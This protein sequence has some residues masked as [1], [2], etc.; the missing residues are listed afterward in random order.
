MKRFIALSVALIMAV[1]SAGCSRKQTWIIADL[2]GS[3]STKTAV[4]LE[5]DFYTAVNKDWLSTAKIPDGY[6]ETSSFADR[7]IEVRQQ[8]MALLND[9]TQTGHEAQLIRTLYAQYTD[10]ETRNALGV[11]PLKPYLDRIMA[12]EDIDDLTEYILYLAENTSMDGMLTY[13]LSAPDYYDSSKKCIWLYSPNFSLG[14]ADEYRNMSY[15]GEI[16]KEA[17]ETMLIKLLMHAGMTEDEAQKINDDFFELETQI[18]RASNGTAA[19]MQEDYADKI[20]NPVTIAELEARSPRYPIVGILQPYIDAGIKDFILAEPAW[21]VHMNELY[22]QE[23]IELF[24][25]YMIRSLIVPMAEIMDEACLEILNE[26]SVAVNGVPYEQDIKAAGLNYCLQQMEWMIG[27]M[28]ADAYANEETQADVTALVEDIL[29]VYK[30]QLENNDRL[31]ESARQMAV[32]KLDNIRVRVGCPQDWTLYDASSLVFKSNEDGGNLVDNFFA[33]TKYYVD[34]YVNMTAAPKDVNRWT[35][36]PHTVTVLYSNTDNSI[37]VTAGAL[38]GA[39]YDPAASDEQNMGRIGTLIA[40]E[41]SHAFDDY[42]SLFDKDGNHY[43][44]WTAE[45]VTAYSERIAEIAAYWGSFD[46][47]KRMPVNGPLVQSEAAA[48]LVGM[49]CMLELANTMEGF[50]YREFFESYAVMW[51]T[52]MTAEEL[53]WRAQNDANP[54]RYLR[55]NATVQQ[56]EEFYDAY[57]IAEGDGMYLAP[58]AR[59]SIW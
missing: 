2:Q 5:D 59:L 41:I 28:Y 54:P 36:A 19:S 42:G 53:E 30:K 7:D 55:I 21:L 13:L 26:Y 52:V 50:D 35:I 1:M 18:A 34:F 39:L 25:A 6:W 9:P 56:F 47:A 22:V 16:Y 58:E 57:G 14:D 11:T 46:A 12:I 33:L 8:I 3:V 40:H 44:W 38:G 10:M 49:S 51:R 43:D 48:D 31:S 27:R 45:D 20:Y 23:N 32:E 24:K 29:T 4:A 17:N 37:H 15:V